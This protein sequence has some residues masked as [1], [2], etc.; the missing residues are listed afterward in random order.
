MI[1]DIGREYP[2]RKET[3]ASNHERVHMTTVVVMQEQNVF[4]SRSV[5]IIFHALIYAGVSATKKHMTLQGSFPEQ[6]S[7]IHMQRGC[8][9]SMSPQS[10]KC[11]V[12]L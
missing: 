12:D 2:Q 8:H 4:S 6:S 10:Y 11:D 5:P 7:A 1:L 3:R 9:F